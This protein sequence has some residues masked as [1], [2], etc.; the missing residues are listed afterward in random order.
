LGTLEAA[1]VGEASLLIGPKNKARTKRQSSD[2]QAINYGLGVCDLVQTGIE[3]LLP[4]YSVRNQMKVDTI[5][6]PKR[7]CLPQDQKLNFLC[8]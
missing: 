8:A 4:P 7:R 1:E 2:V 3:N 5:M 6:L